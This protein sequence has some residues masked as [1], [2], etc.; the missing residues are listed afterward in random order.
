MPTTIT[1]DP[2]TRIEG[3]LSIEITVDDV[4]G[5]QQVV[6]ARSSGTMFRGFEQL[7]LG[8]DPRDAVPY[9]QRICGVCPVSHAIASS[10]T[11]EQAFGL[12]IPANGR[13][14]RNLILGANFIQSHLLHF[15]HLSVV[16][17]VDTTGLLDGVPWEPRHPAADML[18]GSDAQ[19]LVAHYLAAFAM[20]RKA[21]Q[22]GALF[23]GKLPCTGSILAGGCTVEVTPENIAAFRSLLDELRWFIDQVYVPDALLLADRFPAYSGLG[24]GPGNLLAYGAFEL[25]DAG[26][27][28]LFPSGRWDGSD[29]AFDAAQIT[30]HLTYSWFDGAGGPHPPAQGTTVP[31]PDKP[32][33]YTWLKAPRYADQPYELGPLARMWVSGRYRNGISA[34]DRIVARAHET[35]LLAD[36][37]DGWLD[38]LQ[39]GAQGM[40]QAVLPQQAVGAGLTEAPRGGLGHWIAIDN[41]TVDRYQVVTPTNWNTSPRDDNHVPGPLEAGL[42]GTP[43]A[44][45]D[46]P[47]EVVRVAHSFDPCLACAVH[48]FRPGQARSR[49]RVV[50]RPGGGS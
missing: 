37:M 3:H 13:L 49:G 4:G 31:D 39:P 14:L 29:A 38:E 40:A 2:L 50:L 11:L 43:V 1:I 8:R 9:T 7:L 5:Q 35:K 19:D 6:D 20:R 15:F 25:D 16:D 27:D 48:V 44:D 36:A 41:R 23:A 42:I 32:G 10:L 33:A 34:M 18:T 30:E 24:E 22:A 12:T 17:Y 47:L 28:R 26:T 45:L 21:H 46:H